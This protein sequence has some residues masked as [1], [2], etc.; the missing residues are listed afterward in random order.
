MSYII[1]NTYIQLPR[2]PGIPKELQKQF[3][4]IID[5][6][7]V[8]M[9]KLQI[10][11]VILGLLMMALGVAECAMAIKF[12]GPRQRNDVGAKIHVILAVIGLPLALGYGLGFID[13]H[14][15]PA[16]DQRGREIIDL[17]H[18]SFRKNHP[19]IHEINGLLV[20]DNSIM[21]TRY[22][23]IYYLLGR[24]PFA[25]PI[26]DLLVALFFFVLTDEFVFDLLPEFVRERVRAL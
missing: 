1:T 26:I 11:A 8:D 2:V 23:A 13:G 16:F 12:R 25:I 19:K 20:G 15:L 10:F 14:V 5:D 9:A 22:R 7:I 21:S 4:S 6:L 24:I 3:D 18:D 17:V